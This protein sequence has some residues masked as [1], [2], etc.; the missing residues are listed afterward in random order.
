[1][2]IKEGGRYIFKGVHPEG[3]GEL[4]EEEFEDYSELV[5]EIITARNTRRVLTTDSPWT[6]DWVFDVFSEASKRLLNIF[7]SEVVPVI[8]DNV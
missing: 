1:M 8:E 6:G 4:S 3:V 2:E 7:E 5:G